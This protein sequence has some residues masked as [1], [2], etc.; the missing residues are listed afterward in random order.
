MGKYSE[1]IGWV[2][3]IWLTLTSCFFFFPTKFDEH[4]KQTAADFNYTCAVVSGVFLIA[5][6][7][8]FLPRYGARLFFTGPKRKQPQ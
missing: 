6:I 8:W 5:G 4:M 2:S 1:L 3:F 7:Y